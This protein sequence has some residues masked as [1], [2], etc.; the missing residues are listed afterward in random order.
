M[1]IM[2]GLLLLG[3]LCFLFYFLPTIIAVCRGHGYKGVIF[4][5]NLA[6]GWTAIGWLVALVWSVWPKD[7]ALVDPFVGNF[8][9]AGYR[10][11]GDA[12]GASAHGLRRGRYEEEQ[13]DRLQGRA[14]PE[15]LSLDQLEKLASLRDAGI[16]SDHEF[17]FHKARLLGGSY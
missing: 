6:A 15:R 5:I 11:G 4:A 1:E 12:I 16:L 17:Q 2:F 13:R 9:G 8:S 10:T 3:L 14:I 7:R